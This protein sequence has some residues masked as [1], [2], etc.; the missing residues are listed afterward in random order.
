M[1]RATPVASSGEPVVDWARAPEDGSPAT[2]IRQS[3]Q[4]DKKKI[5]I[6]VISKYGRVVGT[7]EIDEVS[8]YQKMLLRR[9]R[10]KKLIKRRKRKKNAYTKTKTYI[11]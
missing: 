9:K 5:M 11:A 1:G 3:P 10:N 4:V 2:E 8:N 6:D 7:Y